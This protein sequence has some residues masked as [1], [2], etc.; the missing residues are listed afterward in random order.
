M[1]TLELRAPPALELFEADGAFRTLE[2]YLD[3]A[4]F[5]SADD[6][7]AE[8]YLGY[9]LSQSI[10]R[11]VSPAP[12][13]PCPLPLLACRIGTSPRDSPRAMSTMARRQA[14]KSPP[15]VRPRRAR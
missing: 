12:P 4:G 6:I 1:K 14:Q 9:G 8:V 10:R 7:A 15:S 13:E 11:D 2:D 3:D 5:W